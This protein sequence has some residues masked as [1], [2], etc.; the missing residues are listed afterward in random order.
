MKRSVLISFLLT[1]ALLGGCIKPELHL[2][3]TAETQ[4]VLATQIN[5]N[6]MWQVNWSVVWTYP[7]N[8]AVNGP[9]GYTVPASMRLHVYPYAADGTLQS[10]QTFNFF[11]TSTELPILV[12]TYDL[13]FHNND[14]EVLLFQY[15]DGELGDIHCST[16]T[17]SNGLRES[18]PVKTIQQ[19]STTKGEVQAPDSEPVVLMPDDLFVLYDRNRQI[20]DNLDDYEYV[21]GK[22]VLK[23]Q[24][25]LDPATYIY[26]FQVRLINNN[27]RIVGSTGGGALTGMAAGVSLRSKV[28]DLS[29]VTVPM[30]VLFDSARDL[31]GSRVACFGQPGYS[32]VLKEGETKAP[33]GTHCLVLNVSYSNGTW[34]NI[35]IDVTE[36]VRALPTGGVIELELDVDDF[37]PDEGGGSGGGGFN[38]LIGGW[39]EETGS[40]TIVN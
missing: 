28:A 24:G 4:I 23:I 32:P 20:T 7:W 27:G 11:G 35:C 1:L 40:T 38:A 25:E 22:Y 34:K 15:P 3:K 16:R 13:L 12:G 39:N 6:V 17:I 5:V 37:P 36:E 14:S 10:H 26:L 9:L 29:T 8:A 18:F 31:L 30:D 21:D 19:K 2:R 33:E